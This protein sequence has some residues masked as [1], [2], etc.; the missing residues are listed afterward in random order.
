MSSPEI[1]P[2]NPES[3]LEAIGEAAK[4]RSEVLRSA[5]SS[6]E[7]SP[8]SAESQAEKARIEALESAVSVEAG[9]TENDKPAEPTT[10]IKRGPATRSNKEAS[11]KR[12]ME[13]V[14]HELSGPSRTFSKAIHNKA[15]EATSDA[16]GRTLMRPSAVLAG[17]LMALVLTFALYMIAKFYGYP[18][19][20]FETIGAFAAGWILGFVYDFL[21]TLLTGK[22]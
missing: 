3:N 13:D 16:L 14:Q 2:A 5:E 4:N 20:G 19:S 1:L 6:V 15:I 11:F 22:R 7:S 10:R 17:S 8:E 18:L 12:T 21:R 9:G